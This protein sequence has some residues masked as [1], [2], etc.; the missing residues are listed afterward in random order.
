VDANDRPPI[1]DA[2]DQVHDERRLL[3][4][5]IWKNAEAL[6]GD[7]RQLE[8]RQAFIKCRYAGE[9]SAWPKRRNHFRVV[10]LVTGIGV[11]ALGVVSS[12]LAAAAGSRRST[13]ITALLILIGVL[14]AV[15]TT[16]NQLVNP[17]AAARQYKSDEFKLRD[18]GWRYLRSLEE[19]GD[20]R[21]A[22]TAFQEEA[23]A[24]LGTEHAGIASSD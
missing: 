10:L 3:V 15:F 12:G 21:S 6:G 14:V 23:S 8:L 13:T 7:E 2:V 19:G 4:E 18:L 9:L 11:A 16:V 5:L 17:G 22:Y 20:P 1:C 24:I